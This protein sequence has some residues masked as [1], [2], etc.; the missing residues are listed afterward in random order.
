MMISISKEDNQDSP[1]KNEEKTTDLHGKIVNARASS[2][3]S[4]PWLRLKDPRIVRVSRA[5]GGKD[6]HSKVCTIRGLR[7]RR[8]RLSVPTAIQLYDLQDRLGLN[9]PSKVIDWLLNAAK[10]EIDELPPLPSMPH[11][12]LGLHHQV[13]ASQSK[14][15]NM[16][17]NTMNWEDDQ[18]GLSTRPNFWSN[19]EFFRAKSKEIARDCVDEKDKY[20]KLN[21][22]DHKQ[23]S[24]EEGNTHPSSSPAGDLMNNPM[25]YGSFFQLE[26]PNF[27]FS[28]G[29][30]NQDNDLHNLNAM[31][32]PSTLSLSSGSQILVAPQP[33]F[34]SAEIDP[35][36]MNHFQML[37]STTQN[38]FTPNPYS[39]NQSPRPLHFSLAPSLFHSLNNENHHPADNK[40]Q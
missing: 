10:N 36:Q 29:F 28:H 16:N 8:V 14:M 23:E 4:T 18:D 32:L 19:E 26:H 20:R 21:E 30:T 34:P 7:D 35:R 39:I 1:T 2:S 15:L 5:F 3:V 38:L 6:R 24:S 12:N 31:P 40:E 11:M 33:Y 9:Q 22:D 37:A 17:N 27:P 25:P 13:G